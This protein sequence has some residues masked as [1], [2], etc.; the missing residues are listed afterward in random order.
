MYFDAHKQRQR[1]SSCIPARNT[2]QLKLLKY[3]TLPTMRYGNWGSGCRGIVG[4]RV[5]LGGVVGPL[6]VLGLG[7]GWV[8]VVLV[9]AAGLVDWASVSVSH[10]LLLGPYCHAAPRA[11]R[12]MRRTVYCFCMR[13]TDCCL[14][15]QQKR[16]SI[17]INPS[18]GDRQSPGKDIY[19]DTV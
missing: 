13:I 14:K 1:Q 17:Q 10:R 8:V 6:V 12:R 19:S 4:R 9:V 16:H 5:P 15:E 7:V 3:G 2:L 11:R 18:E